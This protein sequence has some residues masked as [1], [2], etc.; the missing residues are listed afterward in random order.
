MSETFEVRIASVHSRNITYTSQEGPR[1]CAEY[2]TNSAKANRDSFMH[3]TSRCSVPTCSKKWH[4]SPSFCMLPL[5]PRSSCLFVLPPVSCVR[6]TPRVSNSHTAA[7]RTAHCIHVCECEPKPLYSAFRDPARGTSANL[8]SPVTR[9]PHKT[10]T[11]QGGEHHTDP[12]HTVTSE[13]SH[14]PIPH[15]RLLRLP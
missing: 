15:H 6:S 2:Q 3:T 12:S 9:S 1:L 11:K 8:A 4:I 10:T 13:Q 7:A 14:P 5:W